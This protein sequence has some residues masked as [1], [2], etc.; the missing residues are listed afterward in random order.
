[1]LDLDPSGGT[2]PFSKFL[3]FLKR[4]ADVLTPPRLSIVFRRL[5]RLGSFPACWR[6]GNV[7]L[8][9][10]DPPSSSVASNRLISITSVLS[11]MFERL[12]SVRLGQVMEL[13]GLIPATEFDYRNVW[14][15]VMDFCACPI[16]CKVYW[17]VG[18]RQGSCRLISA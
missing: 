4:T 15:P 18:R 16:H 13:S 17:R 8:I 5:G 14:L 3:L 12:A 6:Q 2:D 10:K 9:P 1:M 11:K 7:T